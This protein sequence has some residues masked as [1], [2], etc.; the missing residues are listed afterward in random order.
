MLYVENLLK[1]GHIL[2]GYFVTVDSKFY[3][4]FQ[5]G[6]EAGAQQKAPL[7]KD[8][9]GGIKDIST[10]Q[11][12]PPSILPQPPAPSMKQAITQDQFD[13][14]FNQYDVDKN[15]KLELKEFKAWFMG[16]N[17]FGPNTV[18]T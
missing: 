12:A 3:L 10:P 15:G 5:L 2:R 11:A 18:Y 6:Q 14:I 16:K 8:D 4:C 13:L 1:N 9:A 7:V 17:I